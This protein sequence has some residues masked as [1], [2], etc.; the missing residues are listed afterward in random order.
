MKELQ[1]FN[2]KFEDVVRH[3][4]LIYDRPLTEEDALVAYDLDCSEF[5]FDIED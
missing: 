2:K 4:L 3:E 1:F 5:T